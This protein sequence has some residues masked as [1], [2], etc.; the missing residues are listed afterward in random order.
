MTNNWLKRL[1]IISNQRLNWLINKY[2]QMATNSRLHIQL[3]RLAE[4]CHHRTSS[5]SLDKLK[6]NVTSTMTNCLE[7]GQKFR[8]LVIQMKKLITLKLWCKRKSCQI[9][10]IIY[11]WIIL[12]EIKASSKNLL[13]SCPMEISVLKVIKCLNSKSNLMTKLTSYKI[14]SESA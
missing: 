10:I 13:Y 4:K 12:V 3:E 6:L 2:N 1:K 7:S 11:M 9:M 8:L 5:M 14:Q